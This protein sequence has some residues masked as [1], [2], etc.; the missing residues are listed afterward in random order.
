M[1]KV[2]S[3][4]QR[5]LTITGNASLNQLD[6]F[7]P[8]GM[9]FAD[10]PNRY[11]YEGSSEWHIT[12]TYL[13]DWFGYPDDHPF[14]EGRNHT[15]DNLVTTCPHDTVVTAV[16]F[17]DAGVAT[18]WAGIQGVDGCPA[19][20][21][22]ISGRERPLPYPQRACRTASAVNTLKSGFCTSPKA[23]AMTEERCL[24][25]ISCQHSPNV[26]TYGMD[27]PL[28]SL[29]QKTIVVSLKCGEPH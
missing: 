8:Q 25:H 16:Y 22:V 9:P 10:D 4:R 12:L 3:T 26:S 1:A 6:R 28:Y 24:G 18:G 7:N 14:Y 20:Y 23:Q 21:H 17:A 5:L 19:S 29:V 13:G 27:C 15:P 11:K 2:R